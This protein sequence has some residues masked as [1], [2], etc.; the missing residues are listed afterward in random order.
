[1]SDEQDTEQAAWAEQQLQERHQR[2]DAA[3]E[4]HRALLEEFQRECHEFEKYMQEHH[5]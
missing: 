2:E 5:V 3:L 4:R 1:M